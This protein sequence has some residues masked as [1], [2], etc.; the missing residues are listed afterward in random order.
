MLAPGTVPPVVW[1][2]C[3]VCFG[4]F[5]RLFALVSLH[6][7]AKFIMICYICFSCVSKCFFLHFF[8]RFC[9]VSFAYVFA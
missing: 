2:V 9:V 3:F 5:A 8:D 1:P 7:G 4:V 6:L